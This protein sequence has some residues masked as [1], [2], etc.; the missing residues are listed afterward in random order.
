MPVTLVVAPVAV[1]ST[2]LFVIEVISRHA[3]PPVYFF[4]PSR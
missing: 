3:A 4:D 1:V 2:I